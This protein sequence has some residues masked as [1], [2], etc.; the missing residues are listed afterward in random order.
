MASQA[1]VRRVTALSTQITD[2]TIATAYGN[3]A[4]SQSVN[5]RVDTGE[6]ANMWDATGT[7]IGQYTLYVAYLTA[8][9]DA[10]VVTYIQSNLSGIDYYTYS[11]DITFGV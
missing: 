8:A 1:L 5:N 10:N 6:Q 7:Y 2:N 9:N 11:S 4:A 3:Y